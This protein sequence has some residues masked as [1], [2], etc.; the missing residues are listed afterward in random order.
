MILRGAMR[1]HILPALA[2]IA[3]G[4]LGCS[5][6]VCNEAAAICGA[7]EDVSADQCKNNEERFAQCIVDRGE[8]SVGTTVDCAKASTPTV[9]GGTS[10]TISLRI[11]EVQYP[12]S[13]SINVMAEIR[14]VSDPSP[15]AVAGPLFLIEDSQQNLHTGYGGCAGGEFLATG[16]ATTCDLQFSLEAGRTPTV[17]RYADGAARTA[18]VRFPV[19][20]CGRGSEDTEANCND[21]CSNDG[22]RF[23]DCDDRDCQFTNVCRGMCAMGPEN[24]EAACSDGCSNDDDDFIDCA[25]FDCGQTMTCGGGNCDS[26]PE[27]NLQACSDGCSN[28][29]DRFIDCDDF[30]CCAVRLDCPAGTACGM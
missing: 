14:N 13:V 12:D 7:P 16:G 2:L 25:D 15:L 8:C 20:S 21:G 11:I 1:P 22:D 23:V 30:D 29:G 17:L 3:V 6:N 27:D 18:Q 19:L 9:G 24:T 10:G 26:G 28:D 5:G 4:G